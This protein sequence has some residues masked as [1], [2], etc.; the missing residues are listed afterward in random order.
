M[1]TAASTKTRTAADIMSR[2]VVTVSP[3]DT[4]Q[5]ALTLLVENHV[6]GLP[7]I[8]QQDRCVAVISMTDI[9]DYEREHAGDSG[10]GMGRCFDA[11]TGRWE[12]VGLMDF[13]LERTG[14]V[15]VAEVMSQDLIFVK[16]NVSI[17]EVAESMMK[18]QVHRILVMDDEQFLC[19]IISS[20]DFVKMIAEG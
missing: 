1:T 9:L 15:A 10:D 13:A 16:P 8:N 12:E 6:T 19:G 11:E 20:F 5:D 18:A 4:L 17:E 2:D 14:Q 3:N 7:V